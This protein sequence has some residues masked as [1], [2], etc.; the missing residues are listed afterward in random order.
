MQTRIIVIEAISDDSDTHNKVIEFL[1]SEEINT[2]FP[3]TKFNLKDGIHA[4]KAD[5]K[6]A[7]RKK[8]AK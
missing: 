7:A 5:S 3:K 8:A 1:K 6:K 2:R 4:G